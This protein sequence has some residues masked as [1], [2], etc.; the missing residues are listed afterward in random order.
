MTRKVF[1]GNFIFKRQGGKPPAILVLKI[2]Y[3]TFNKS[4]NV[5]YIPSLSVKGFKVSKGYYI[6]RSR[7]PSNFGGGG[8]DILRQVMWTC[9]MNAAGRGRLLSL[10]VCL[11]SLVRARAGALM[12]SSGTHLYPAMQQQEPPSPAAPPRVQ[13]DPLG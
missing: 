13:S 4:N 2:N 12:N 11:L 1:T 6:L 9:P 8:G 3:P 10:P 5:T 7:S